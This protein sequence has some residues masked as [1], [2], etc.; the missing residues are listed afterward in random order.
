MCFMAVLFLN[1]FLLQRNNPFLLLNAQMTKNSYIPNS[2][3]KNYYN[4]LN[5]VIELF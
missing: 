3:N 5:Q 2:K 1:R 4:P